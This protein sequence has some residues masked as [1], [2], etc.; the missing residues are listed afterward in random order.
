MVED[1]IRNAR[2]TA[3]GRKL[4]T[5]EQKLYIVNAWEASNLSAPEFCRRHGLLTPVLYLWRKNA[6]RGAIMSMQNDG[7][8]HSKTEMDALKKENEELKLALAEAELHKRV[9][10]K[11]L[12]MDELK[13]QK[14]NLYQRNSI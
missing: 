8:L 6:K 7:E 9:L 4:F 11:K 1:V 2:L 12:E 3:S 10:K 5:S 13:K 14:S